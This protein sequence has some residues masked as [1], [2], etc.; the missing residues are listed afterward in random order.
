MHKRTYMYTHFTSVKCVYMY[1]RLTFNL[2]IQL[3][4]MHTQTYINNC[5]Y[6]NAHKDVCTRTHC[7]HTFM[8][9]ITYTNIIHSLSTHKHN[10]TRS[11]THTHMHTHTYTST[12]ANA[13][14]HLNLNL[15]LHWPLNF[16]MQQNLRLSRPSAADFLSNSN[17]PIGLNIIRLA[18]LTDKILVEATFVEMI[19]LWLGG[20]FCNDT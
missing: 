11:H 10:R 5:I 14:I 16:R 1:V 4:H 9:K 6:S 12:H 13:Y 20:L 17:Q 15:L 7:V 8:Y 18:G 3:I 2:Q 19:K